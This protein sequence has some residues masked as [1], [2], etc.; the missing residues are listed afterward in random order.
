MR[1][2]MTIRYYY[3]FHKVYEERGQGVENTCD[4]SRGMNS[5][6]CVITKNYIYIKVLTIY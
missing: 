1:L 2:S 4:F 5:I 3:C 6:P